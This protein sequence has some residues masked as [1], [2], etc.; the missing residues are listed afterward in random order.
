MNEED[1]SL[2]AEMARR[3]WIILAL[4]LAASALARNLD[5]TLGLLWG[6]LTAVAGY[7]WLHSALVKALQRSDNATI[8]SFQIGY[9][10][11]LLSL[12]IVLGLLI[13][14][15]K[16]NIVGLVI[17]LSVVVINIFWTTVK[18]IF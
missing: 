4:L 2:L 3:N 11:R 6:G 10:L 1:Q 8:R 14:V 9:L 17:G 18:R 13:A 7:Q 16:V 15:A 12:A 5:F